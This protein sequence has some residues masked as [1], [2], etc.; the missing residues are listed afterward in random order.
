MKGNKGFTLIELLATI[1]ILSVITIIAVP[2]VNRSIKNAKE[3]LY[4]VQI[5]YIEAG[6]K[7]WAAENV[8]SLPQEHDESLT[9]TLGQL[10][11]S[12][13]VEFDIRNPKTKELFPNDMEITITKY[14]NTYIYDVIEDSGNPNNDLDITLPTI[15]LV[16]N[17]LEYVNV[18]EPFIDPGVIA[19][20]SAGVI[21]D[22]DVC[23]DC[24]EKTIYNILGE[25]VD[26]NNFTN[27]AGQYTIKYI[28]KQ[29][30]GKTATAIRTVWVR[31]V[32]TP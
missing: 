6:A 15:E 22:I 16:G 29:A 18:G 1:I 17:A 14:N 31:A 24:F 10:K 9:L 5:S 13:F 12:G 7:A 19:K 28:V 23:D 11:M 4:Q 21:F 27:T 25:T 8:F 30:D 32:P 3:K 20:N 2:A 26:E